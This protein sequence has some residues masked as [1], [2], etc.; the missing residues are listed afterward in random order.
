MRNIPPRP[1]LAWYTEVQKNLTE[2]E[3][4]FTIYKQRK[5]NMKHSPPNPNMISVVTSMYNGELCPE[6]L[7]QNKKEIN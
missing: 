6:Y 3:S 5:D 7:E 1:S 4:L 2:L